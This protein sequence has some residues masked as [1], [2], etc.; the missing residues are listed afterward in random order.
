MRLAI[1]TEGGEVPITSGELADE[2]GRRVGL[3]T[4]RG[5]IRRAIEEIEAAVK[6]ETLYLG[7]E[8]K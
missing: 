5:A 7:L 1:I 6:A 2:I 4:T 8:H 3:I